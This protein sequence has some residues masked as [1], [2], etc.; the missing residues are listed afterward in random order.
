M[1]K[2]K[3]FQHVSTVSI[4]NFTNVIPDKSFIYPIN[5]LKPKIAIFY[6]L[7]GNAKW[8]MIRKQNFPTVKTAVY[9]GNYTNIDINGLYEFDT[10]LVPTSFNPIFMGKNFRYMTDEEYDYYLGLIDILDDNLEET[11][12]VLHS[13]NFHLYH[14]MTSTP[15]LVEI[16]E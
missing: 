4:N 8:D 13:G 2:L 9:F 1:S 16:L 7:D 14:K 5:N 11:K 6:G 10:V 12:K 3:F 15:P